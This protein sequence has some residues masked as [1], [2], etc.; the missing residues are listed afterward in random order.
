L[1]R[2]PRR[3][4]RRRAPV[5]APDAL[6]RRCAVTGGRFEEPAPPRRG[7]RSPSPRIPGSGRP[8]FFPPR[9]VRHDDRCRLGRAG[10]PTAGGREGRCHRR[11]LRRRAPPSPTSTRPAS[12]S[13]ARTASCSPSCAATGPR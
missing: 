7:S 8:I 4:R 3:H 1:G 12:A 2:R 9:R 11:G 10:P 5:G 13:G 6:L